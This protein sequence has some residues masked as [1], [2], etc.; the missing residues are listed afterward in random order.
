MGYGASR[1]R[2]RNFIGNKKNIRSS[3]LP[4]AWQAEHGHPFLFSTEA[5]INLADDDNCSHDG[6]REL[7]RGL[8][9]IESPDEHLIMA[10]EAEH[11]AQPRRQRSR[12]YG[13]GMM[14]CRLHRRFRPEESGVAQG[15][16]DA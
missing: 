11:A 16:D 1:F 9:G 15:N 3:F 2:R 5:S 8:H 14:V 4:R 13:A 6:A 12:I 10:Q 7:F